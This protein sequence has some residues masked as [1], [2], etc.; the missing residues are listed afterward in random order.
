[1]LKL[2][3]LRF[4][5]ISFLFTIFF[6]FI[7]EPVTAQFKTLSF[8]A[9]LVNSYMIGNNPGASN[10]FEVDSTK[11]QVYGGGFRGSQPGIGIRVNFDVGENRRFTIPFGFDY[12]FY[13]GLQRMSGIEYK[14]KF[15]GSEFIT[16]YYKNTVGIASVL[17][18]LNYAMV[19]FNIAQARIYAGGELRGTYISENTYTRHVAYFV[20]DSNEYYTLPSKPSAFRLGAQLKIGLDGQLR[21]NVYIDSFIGIGIVNLLLRDDSRGE[22]LTPAKTTAFYIE[23]KETL[24]FNLFIGLILQYRL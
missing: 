22:L 5:S 15:Y 14:D 21:E 8:S 16:S 17:L 3:N 12:Y 2:F 13:E 1:M 6:V 20:L 7:I 11:Q 9:G 18:G 23:N 24:V 4:I 19:K 10:F